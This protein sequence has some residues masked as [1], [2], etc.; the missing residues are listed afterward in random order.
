MIFNQLIPGELIQNQKIVF[1]VYSENLY[2][3]QVINLSKVDIHL[4]QQCQNQRMW[5][6]TFDEYTKLLKVSFDMIRYIHM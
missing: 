5:I 4:F 6:N 1:I 2:A 3:Y